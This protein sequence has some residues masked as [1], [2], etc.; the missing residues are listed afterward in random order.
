MGSDADDDFRAAAGPGDVERFGDE[1]GVAHV[2]RDA[3]TPT[4]RG[5]HRRDTVRSMLLPAAHHGHRGVETGELR[6]DGPPEAGA[7]AGDDHDLVGETAGRQR[8][9]ALRWWR[10]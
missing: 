7:A 4:A 9:R 2:A 3:Q 1:C 10:G 6:G 5:L 8:A